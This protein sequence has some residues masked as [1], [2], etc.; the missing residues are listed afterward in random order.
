M[1]ATGAVL[2][3]RTRLTALNGTTNDTTDTGSNAR[4]QDDK[5]ERELL[6]LLLVDIGNQTKRDTTTGSRKTT[7]FTLAEVSLR[8]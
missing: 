8:Q 6:C 2:K 3:E 5:G 1:L 7:L 4:R